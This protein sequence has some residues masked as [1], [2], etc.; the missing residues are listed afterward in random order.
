METEK[1]IERCRD[2]LEKCNALKDEVKNLQERSIMILDEANKLLRKSMTAFW[3]VIGTIV[4]GVAV[5]R[6]LI[7][8][9]TMR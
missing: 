4:L 9:G 3:L 5:I 2:C 7:V 1:Y 8:S 6:W